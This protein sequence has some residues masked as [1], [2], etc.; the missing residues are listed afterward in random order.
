MEEFF[1]YNGQE[2]SFSDVEK[3]ALQKELS[4]D[5]YVE[6]FGLERQ[7]RQTGEELNQISNDMDSG[8]NSM[9]NPIASEVA[10]QPVYNESVVS[11]EQ[12]E[13][14]QNVDRTISND[15]ILDPGMQLDE[16]AD[17]DMGVP[18]PKPVNNE[19]DRQVELYNKGLEAYY[20]NL[21]GDNVISDA[22]QFIAPKVAGVIGGFAK[23]LGSLWCP[24]SVRGN[25]APWS[26]ASKTVRGENL[27][28]VAPMA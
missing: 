16:N 23:E 10:A 5:E 13:I 28:P 14:D 27:A 20:D 26:P 8:I 4:I 3:A 21:L 9:S 6:E 17:G 1:I 24:K 2:F 22:A 25:L 15:E 7:S 19:N 12:D 11:E 18:T